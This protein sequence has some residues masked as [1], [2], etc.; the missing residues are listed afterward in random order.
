MSRPSR[1]RLADALAI[2]AADYQAQAV[3]PHC[4]TC[5]RPCCKLDPLVLE[6]NWQ[7]LKSLWQIEEARSAFD[8]R[9]AAGNGPQEIRAADGLYFVHGKTC[10]A[11]DTA[12]GGCRVYDQPVKPVGCSDFPVYED[13]G[14]IMADLRCEAVE[15][16]AL[17][18]RLGAAIGDDFRIVRQADADFPFLVTLS[19]KKRRPGRK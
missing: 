6:L 14:V 16:E 9:L 10:P 15:L 2:A 18:A 11:Y 8:K 4:R 7:Q 5:S 13:G 1:P 12:S 3:I 19:P 17:S